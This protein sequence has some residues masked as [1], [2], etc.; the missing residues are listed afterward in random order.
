EIVDFVADMDAAGKRLP[1]AIGTHS[2]GERGK[3]RQIVEREIT[4]GAVAAGTDVADAQREGRIEL[5]GIDEIEK[6]A[7]GVNAGEGGLG[8]DVHPVSEDEASDAPAV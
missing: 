6:G 7:L 2:I 1:C 5:R 3:R 4:L 8:G